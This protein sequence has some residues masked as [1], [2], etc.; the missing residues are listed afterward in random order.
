MNQC[1]AASFLWAHI[2]KKYS[3]PM[4]T[5]KYI[6]PNSVANIIFFTYIEEVI[7]NSFKIL[8]YIFL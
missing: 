1:F 3:I 8:L 4:E 7:Y 2:L 5:N 6:Q